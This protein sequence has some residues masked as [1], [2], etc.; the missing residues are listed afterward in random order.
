MLR[1][2]AFLR[3]LSDTGAEQRLNSLQMRSWKLHAG[4]TCTAGA[5]IS[6]AE[7]DLRRIRRARVLCSVIPPAPDRVGVAKSPSDSILDSAVKKL[8]R[9]KRQTMGELTEILS[10]VAGSRPPQIYYK[11]Y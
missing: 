10:N 2:T 8:L 1:S 11:S 9:R 3:R 6:E 7:I 4:R 5:C